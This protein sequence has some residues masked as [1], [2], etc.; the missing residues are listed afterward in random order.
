MTCTVEP[1][2]AELFR[3]EYDEI[4]LNTAKY[5]KNTTEY[6]RIHQ[7]LHSRIQ[8]RHMY[9][10]VKC[11]LMYS[12]VFSCILMYSHVLR[13][14]EMT[15]GGLPSA[16]KTSACLLLTNCIL[17]VFSVYSYV[18]NMSRSW[19]KWWRIRTEYNRIQQNTQEYQEVLF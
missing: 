19:A 7:R 8:A 6:T 11:I 10:T 4:L 13:W 14:P 18:F 5:V 17:H 9:S 15:S 12:H 2:D 3:D 16:W 1:L